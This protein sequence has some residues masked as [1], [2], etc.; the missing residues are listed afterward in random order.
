VTGTRVWTGSL[1][2]LASL[3]CAIA[4]Y[5]VFHDNLPSLG[6]QPTGRS[7]PLQSN[8]MSPAGG[9]LGDQRQV[10]W[11]GSSPPLLQARGTR[12]DFPEFG[13]TQDDQETDRNRADLLSL[14]VADL[15]LSAVMDEVRRQAPI[16]VALADEVRGSRITIRFAD[17]PLQQGLRRLLDGLDTWYLYTGTTGGPSRLTSVWVFPKGAGRESSPP[18]QAIED[19]ARAPRNQP[20]RRAVEQLRDTADADPAVRAQAIAASIEHAG[21]DAGDLVASALVD[22][23]EQVRMSAIGGAGTAAVDMD[24]GMLEVLFREDP[25]PRVRAMALN[26]RV[27]PRRDDASAPAQDL[28]LLEEALQDPSPEVSEF[29]RQ[30]LETV[31]DA[32]EAALASTTDPNQ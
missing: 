22:P 23:D 30:A 28:E 9:Q 29:A 14:D 13:S 6:S 3:G 24:P 8:A 31:R 10:A 19:A 21:S 15:P 4:V 16:T 11:S 27:F 5:A 7:A 26:A 18:R 17:Q 20:P 25:S 12:T 32:E 2:A 1:L